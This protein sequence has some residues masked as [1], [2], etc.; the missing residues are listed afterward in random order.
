MRYDVFTKWLLAIC[1]L[2]LLAAPA[3]FAGQGRKQV[4]YLNS[5]QNGYGWSDN[6][7]HGIRET[8]RKSPYMVDLQVEYMDAKKHPGPDNLE[9]LK[10][11]FTSKFSKTRFDAIIVSDNAA[12][13]FIVQTHEE[14]FPGV[15]VVFCGVNDLRPEVL[16]DLKG[17]S[18]VREELDIVYNLNL[19]LK[20]DPNKE[21]VVV[22]TDSSLSSR[23]IA[24]QIRAA[25]PEFKGRLTFEFWKDVPM[26]DLLERS[27]ALPDNCL[28]FCVPFYVATEGQYL[29]AGD[30][31][32]ALYRNSDAPIYGA[33]RFLL[34]HGVVGG[35]LLDGASQGRAAAAMVV[36]N[37]D[38][39]STDGQF[40]RAKDDSPLVFDWKVLERFDLLEAPLPAGAEFINRPG[41][42]YELEKSVVWSVVIFLFTL[43]CFSVMMTTSRQRAVRA[44]KELALSR[45]MLRTII[46]TIPQLIYWKDLKS[47]YVGVNRRFA[48]FFGLGSVEEAKGKVNRDFITIEGF[49]DK[50]E[51]MDKQ[52]MEHNTPVLNEV[53]TYERGDQRELHLEIS[54]IPLYDDEGN[55][56]GVLTTAE[57]ISSRVELERELIQSRK[58][59][60]V[61]TFVG[62]IAHDFNN[63]LTTVINSAE[64][65]LMDADGQVADDVSR[66]KAAAEQGTQLVRQILSYARPSRQGAAF[67]DAADPVNEALDLVEA[68]LPD[69]THLERD[70]QHDVGWGMADPA[71][72]QQIVMNLCT[73]SQHAMRESG[74]T[75]TVHLSV[76]KVMAGVIS[77]GLAP[78]RML[79]LKVHDNGPGIPPDMAERVFDPF[80]STK[81]RG[82]G[83]GLGLAIV[84]GIVHGHGGLVRLASYPGDTVFDI[85][86]PFAEGEAGPEESV[87]A[88]LEGVERILFVE[89][90]KDQLSLVPRALTGLGYDVVPANGGQV[91]LDIMASGE[92][93]DL[94]VTDFD[95]PGFHGVDLARTLRQLDPDLPVV[96]VSGGRE[97]VAAA[98]SEPAV[99]KI[100]LKP[101]TGSSLAAAIR[102]VLDDTEV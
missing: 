10:R 19:A 4:L 28:L 72:L 31:L 70:V 47:R 43:L 62:G 44:E 27:R 71:H 14:L 89:D 34:G 46:D 99:A 64:L 98:Q 23:A 69:N 80:Y 92:N 56:S 90:D 35:R 48:D 24:A 50:G 29:S 36:E 66:A 42:T 82:E 95:L 61:G 17:F 96:L 85:L 16:K 22:V 51:K 41:R 68:M 49:I 45:E 65:A 40:R 13:Q 83:T 6:I 37:L 38:G 25:I 75:I 78:G 1:L 55:I 18:G 87:E 86:I 59:E 100:V 91:A 77:P 88:V 97:A 5:Y 101:Y 33:W 7:L 60:A 20:L 9:I 93:F 8:F 57:D 15:P 81:E 52:V 3:S 73:N 79:R 12:F 58:M 11:L 76:E 30:V 54:K 84:Q 2:G 21:R 94:V 74:G 102:Q 39:K 63:L 53:L 32:E 26:D 67:I